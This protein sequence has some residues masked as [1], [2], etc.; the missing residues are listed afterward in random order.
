[1]ILGFLIILVILFN[2]FSLLS[3][4]EPTSRILQDR[5]L[6]RVGDMQGDPQ[7]TILYSALLCGERL[8]EGVVKK[9]FVALGIIHLMVV[10]GAHLIFLERAWS[11]LPRFRFKDSLLAVFLLLYSLSAG[12]HPPV[13]RALFSLLLTRL[14]KKLKL[15]WS[16][17]VR[18]QMS[19]LLC[20]MCFRSWFY[21]LSL[22]LSWIASMGM[23]NYRLS[24][25]KSCV[26]T[27]FLILPIVSHW[28][29]V[30]PL[31]ILLNWLVA[32]LAGSLLLPL[33]LLTLV[34]PFLRYVT[35][36][37]WGGFLFLMNQLRPV[38]ENQGVELPFALSSFQIWIYIGLCFIF[39]QVYFTSS[40]RRACQIKEE[41]PKALPL[42]IRK[43]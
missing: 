8:P 37:L 35:D 31:S 42:L 20:L 28:G 27:F 33:S 38:M 25:L 12:L 29:G 19:G 21:S 5:C 40:I 13:V 4:V 15:F 22:Q 10:S 43:D 30:H 36:P 11:L 9:T 39:L 6:Q 23:S 18:V 7:L 2:P 3:V 34:F 26:L 14:D 32:P 17:Y 1:M 24:R 41:K 16:P